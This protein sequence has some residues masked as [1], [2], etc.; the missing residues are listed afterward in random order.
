M[1]HILRDRRRLKRIVS[2]KATNVASQCITDR[3]L[4]QSDTLSIFSEI[5]R[6][7]EIWLT[8]YCRQQTVAQAIHMIPYSLEL[9]YTMYV[10]FAVFCEEKWKKRRNAQPNF[11]TRIISLKQKWKEQK[12]SWT[13][14]S[15]C[16]SLLFCVC[17]FLFLHAVEIELNVSFIEWV[18]SK[19]WHCSQFL[20]LTNGLN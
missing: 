20:V 17:A 12:K 11:G 7:Y 6:R 10:I 14:S 16:E 3:K 13:L 15:T 1:I 18:L 9:F 19:C 5:P 4:T 8:D 2:K